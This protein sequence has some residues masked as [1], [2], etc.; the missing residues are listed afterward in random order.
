MKDLEGKV[1][2]VTGSASGIGLE[3]TREL[4]R[5][6][7]RVMMADI[8]G[9]ALARAYDDLGD[10]SDQVRRVV[11]DVADADAVEAAA[12]ATIAAFGK[13]HLVCNNAGVIAGGRTE[14]I[15]ACDWEWV[16]SVNLM[17]V[18]N[19]IR[20]FLPRIKAQGEGGHV[21]NTS[22][23]AGLFAPGMLGPYGASKFAVVG[24]SEG[25]AVELA[26]TGIYVSVVC[27]SYVNTRIYDSGRNRQARFGGKPEIPCD[28]ERN[29]LAATIPLLRSGMGPDTVAKRI[30]EAVGENELY[31]FTET[32]ML[33]VCE[34]RF[35]AIHTEDAELVI[36][37]FGTLAR[38]ARAAVE[39]LRMEGVRVGLFRPISLWPFPTDALVAATRTAARVACLEQNAGQMIEDVKLSLLGSIPVI[40][41]GGISTDAAGFGIGALLDSDLIRERAH[42]V[43]QGRAVDGGVVI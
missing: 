7:M 24:L 33:Q 36:V 18:V 2:F 30:V 3:L 19:G 22:S 13:V 31:I 37:A 20:A 25:L 26:G 28:D 23:G 38:F 39:E 1:A 43:F 15:A 14:E 42:A 40:P 12:D 5:A 16:L 9:D 34:Q 29:P 41:I 21:V 8:E 11:C 4:A 35:E 32:D 6:G 17:G 10:L 27:P